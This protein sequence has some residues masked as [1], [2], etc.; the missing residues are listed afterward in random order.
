MKLW[1]KSVG[2]IHKTA[3]SSYAVILMLIHYL[4]KFKEVKPILDARN[5]THDTPHFKFKRVKQGVIE[6]FDVF[7][8]FKDKLEDV[9]TVERVNYSRIL[10]DF[11]STT[12]LIFGKKKKLPELLQSIKVWTSPL[13]MRLR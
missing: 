5:R 2:L 1:G 3:L 4:I 11:S 9:S 13:T 10:R 7:Y 12:Q 8:T 6:Q